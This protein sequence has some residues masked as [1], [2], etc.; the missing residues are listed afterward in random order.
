[1]STELPPRKEED[2][3]AGVLRLRLGGQ[4]RGLRIVD[5][6]SAVYQENGDWLIELRVE[7][8]A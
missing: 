6:C 5:V 3:L 8:D 7:A 2:V 1:M 4:D